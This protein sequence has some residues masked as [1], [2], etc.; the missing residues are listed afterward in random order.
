MISLFDMLTECYNSEISNVAIAYNEIIKVLKDRAKTHKYISV[1]VSGGTSVYP[2]YDYRTKTLIT[3]EKEA[4]ELAAM[5]GKTDVISV[6]HNFGY[7]IHDRFIGIKINF[8]WFKRKEDG[9]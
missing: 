4:M 2:E 9:K 3:N 8:E 7:D 5:I 1:F 6:V